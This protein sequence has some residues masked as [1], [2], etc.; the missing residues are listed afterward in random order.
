[1]SILPA[2]LDLLDSQ[3]EAALAALEGLDDA[4]LWQRPAPKAWS[5]GEI[6]DHNYLLIASSV[7]YVEFVWK[8]FRGYGERRRGRAYETEI[9]DY[10]HDPVFPMWV[11]FLWTPRYNPRKT[12]PLSTLAR[13]L[14]NLHAGVRDFYIDKPEDVLGN[15][16]VYDPYFGFLNLIKTLRL[17][18]Y[19]DQLHYADVIK[20]AQTLRGPTS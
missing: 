15:L 11:G 12:T 17:G 19:H 9:A 14:R 10:Y 5:I 4:Q 7:P 16:Y 13:E 6:L 3:R 20:Q 1:M 8:Y 2:Y 18:I